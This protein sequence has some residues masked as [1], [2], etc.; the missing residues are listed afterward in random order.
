MGPVEQPGQRGR[1][2]ASAPA[3]RPAARLSRAEIVAVAIAIA[4]QDGLDAVSMRRVAAG[5]SSG[6]MSLYR[7]VA[8]REQLLDSMVDAVYSQMNLPARP[9]GQWRSDLA[10][11]ARA[12]RR[13][14]SAHPW[15]ASLVGSRPPL[16]PGFLRSFDF[17]LGALQAAGLEITDA[18]GAAATTSA[19]V[20]GFVLLEHAEREARRRTGLTRE[21][22]R[23]RNAPLVERILASGDYPAV[24]R[25]VE[26]ARDLDP[27]AAFETALRRILDGL[28]ASLPESQ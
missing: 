18:A 15:A 24:M 7:H 17:A 9:S 5:L 11:L 10:L 12:Q 16:L 4:D 22:W 8:S 1:H 28:Q 3:R 13:L 25:F 23:A 6:T 27:D 21:Q 19:F 26:H 20:V 2:H 14:M